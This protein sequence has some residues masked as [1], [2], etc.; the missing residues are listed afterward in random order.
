MSQYQARHKPP[1]FQFPRLPLSPPETT[2]HN[3]HIRG[4]PHTVPDEPPFHSSD[5]LR[6]QSAPTV[7]PTGQRYRR[8][9]SIAYRSS[10]I[11]DLPQERVPSR[12]PRSFIIIVP[13]P[14]FSQ[15]DGEL[16][17]TLG[18]GPRHRLSEGLIMPLFPTV[19]PSLRILETGLLIS[20]QLDVRSTDG[21]S[22]R[23]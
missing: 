1:P 20:Y 5:S 8:T 21:Y 6:V 16:G 10:G 2:I 11:N 12:T 3:N 9:S 18:L 17:H 22:S 7:D 15:E 23:V 13:P 14:A 19:S 4:V